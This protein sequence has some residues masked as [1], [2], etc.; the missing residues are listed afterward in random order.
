MSATKLRSTESAGDLAT[1]V[2]VLL[3]YACFSVAISRDAFARNNEIVDKTALLQIYVIRPITSIMILHDTAPDLLPGN[4]SPVISV[5]AA[6]GEYEP[7]SFVLR[8]LVDLTSVRA[9]VTEIKTES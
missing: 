9:T 8:P 1:V 6:P 2:M 5:I 3:A 4:R 7:A